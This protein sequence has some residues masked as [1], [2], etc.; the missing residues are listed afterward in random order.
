[1]LNQTGSS[2]DWGSSV[3]W[4]DRPARGQTFTTGSNVAGYT[5]DAI[6][7]QSS[8]TTATLPHNTSYAVRVGTV[9]GTSFA[10]VASESA[11]YSGNFSAND[12]VTFTLATPISLSPNSVYGFDVA[13]TGSN[14][15]WSDSAWMLNRNAQTEYADGSAYSSGANG[16]GGSTI[17]LHNQDRIFHLNMTA[18]PSP[19]LVGQLGILDLDAN[20]GINPATGNPWQAGDQYRLAFVT[21]GKTDAT[22]TDINR[23]NAFVQIT[24]DASS[25]PLSDTSWKVI[26]ST[27]TVNAKVNTATDVGT[28]YSIFR[29]DGST[30]VAVNNADLW[31][32]VPPDHVP[33]LDEEGNFLNNRVVFAGTTPSGATVNNRWLGTTI[34]SKNNNTVVVVETG[35]TTPNNTGRWIQQYNQSPTSLQSFYA[36][37][38]LLTLR[39]AGGPPPARPIAGVDFEGASQSSFDRNPDDLDPADGIGVSSGTGG[40]MFDGWTLVNKGNGGSSSGLLRNDG[41]ANSAGA[42]TPNYPARLEGNS[43]GSWSITIPHDFR[44]DLDRIEFDVRAATGGSGRDGRFNTSLDGSDFLWEDYSLPGRNTGW[45]HVSV[46]LSGDLYQNLRGQTLSFIWDTTT[47]GAID[48]DTIRVYGVAQ[49]VP[50]PSTFALAALGMLG[51]GWFGWRRR[52][53]P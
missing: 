9:S 39:E 5:L 18:A 22:S 27:E 20:G 34:P 36:I 12:Y 28:G 8:G 21:S 42:T 38:D 45:L 37:S 3:I 50:E 44:L 17:S 2:Y 24:A 23:Y 19:E 31:N 4:T 40:T 26:A 41:G 43:T 14:R 52:R 10:G 29:M 7:V 6:T 47:S 11:S 13:L 16:A 33:N 1:M 53:L 35:L 51:L 49:Y 15:G 32:G 46:D 30:V 48:L 25:L